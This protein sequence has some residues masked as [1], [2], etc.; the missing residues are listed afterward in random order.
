MQYSEL[1][2][3]VTVFCSLHDIR[4][5]QKH[6]RQLVITQC[7]SWGIGLRPLDFWNCGFGSRLRAW[8]SRLS[9]VCRQVEVSAT[10]RSLVQRS[11][12]EC[13]SVWVIVISNCLSASFHLLEI[14]I[15][16]LSSLFSL[17]LEI[18]WPELR[19]VSLCSCGHCFMQN[20]AGHFH[21]YLC[22]FSSNCF[23]DF[24]VLNCTITFDETQI[25]TYCS[26]TALYRHFWTRWLLLT[27]FDKFFCSHLFSVVVGGRTHNAFGRFRA[28]SFSSTHRYAAA[29]W[30]SI[31]QRLFHF[32]ANL[33]ARRV[34]FNA[35]HP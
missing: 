25:I 13:V 5:S 31:A 34:L 18:E 20:T 33:C 26:C 12:T 17:N 7:A 27:D 3:S 21:K 6:V 28:K 14:F 35:G 22:F 11:L 9:G 24:K 32:L 15:F 4:A 8:M 23:A 10:G 16:F 30:P 29:Y 1:M 2:H 19:R